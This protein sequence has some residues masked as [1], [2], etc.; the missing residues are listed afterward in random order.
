MVNVREIFRGSEISQW[1][2]SSFKSR[3]AHGKAPEGRE[4]SG[5][6]PLSPMK[7]SLFS[8]RLPPPIF[9]VP[10]D[11]IAQAGLLIVDRREQ[12]VPL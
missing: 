2:Q 7:S 8:K 12:P 1:Q 4:S 9:A 11:R 10:E 6:S 5:Y 3:V